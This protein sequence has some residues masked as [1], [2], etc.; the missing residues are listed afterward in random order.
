MSSTLMEK[1]IL[2]VETKL[3]RSKISLKIL[4]AKAQTLLKHYPDYT[5]TFMALT[6]EDALKEKFD[7]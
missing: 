5:P 3:N 6:L 2:I 1:K 7:L 4:E